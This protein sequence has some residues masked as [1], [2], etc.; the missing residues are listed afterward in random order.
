MDAVDAHRWC[1]VAWGMAGVGFLYFYY[2]RLRGWRRPLGAMWLGLMLAAALAASLTAAQLLPVI[3]FS[4]LTTR[5][6]A[7]SLQGVYDF[8]VEPYRLAELIWP[9][10]GGIQY[11]ENS[12]WPDLIRIP[13][14]YPRIWVPSLYLGGLTVILASAALAVR[15]GPPWR[16]WLSVIAVVSLLGG[17]GQYTSPIWAARTAV[18]MAHSPRLD[19]LAEGL[20]PVD[21]PGELPIRRDGF[22]KDGD[23][24]IYWWLATLLPGFRQFRFPA[25]L[26]TF[27]SLALTALA[28]MGWDRLCA[29]C[30]R[31]APVTIGFLIVVSLCVLAGVVIE[32][33]RILAAFG[34]YAGT[35]ASGPLNADKGY[36]AIVRS[37]VH[38][39]L[40]LGAGLAMVKL[41]RKRPHLA[42]AAALIVMALDLAA[43]NSRYVMTVEQSMFDGQPRLAQII[44]KAEAERNPQVPGPFR[45]HRMSTW[46][47]IIWNVTSSKDREREFVAWERG[48][49]APKYGINFG[50]EYTHTT[51][52]AELND[53][54]WYFSGFHRT[55]IGPEVAKWL[56]TEV[57]T[58]VVYFPR[59]A[60][61]MWNTRYFVVP[62]YANGWRDE[63]RALQPPSASRANSILSRE[64]PV[65]RTTWQSRVEEVD[66]HSGFRSPAQRARVSSFVGR[67]QRE[68]DQTRRRPV[69]QASS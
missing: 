56:G 29:G 6:A 2:W 65:R 68:S 47:P 1:A 9:D 61:D 54:D 12:Y 44:E 51:G 32:R 45:V 38:C 16:V 21:A 62:A 48:T 5:A 58:Q 52:V 67:A 18:A 50:I 53:Y 64:R 26:F 4:Q 10:F 30:A 7:D 28:G 14:V 46:N 33:H 27:T 69:A 13:G 25:K 15:R 31:R 8:S 22:L 63:M 34:S 59:R 49:I 17:L 42:G 40:V 43:A 57:G 66:G 11:G 20:G 39:L 35:S 3:E 55:A 41:A 36:E 37:L 60:F 19:R 23:G 24:S